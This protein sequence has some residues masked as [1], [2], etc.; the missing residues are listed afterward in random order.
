MTTGIPAQ[1]LGY[2]VVFVAASCILVVSLG[3]LSRIDADNGYSEEHAPKIPEQE[4]G[5]PAS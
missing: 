3:V 1:Y 5:S 2:M 4:H